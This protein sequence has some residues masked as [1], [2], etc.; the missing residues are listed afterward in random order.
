MGHYFRIQPAGLD[1]KGH[2][3]IDGKTEDTSELADGLHAFMY[4]WQT[5]W[6]DGDRGWYGDEVVVIEA[7]EDWDNGDVEGVCID[8][9]EAKIVARYSWED[10]MSLWKSVIG[11]DS[12]EDEFDMRHCELDE[13]EDKV[14]E[15]ILNG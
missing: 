12:I 2:F 15:V 9:M 3:S 6:T 10:W 1:V 13:Y 7:S 11:D 8:P 5:F 4:S 14:M